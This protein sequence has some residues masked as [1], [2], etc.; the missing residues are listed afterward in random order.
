[1]TATEVPLA[2]AAAARAVLPLCAPLSRHRQPIAVSDVGA[3][4]LAV[5][6][7]VPTALLNGL[8]NLASIDD[9]TLRRAGNA[10][11]AAMVMA[12][13]R[14]WPRCWRS[15]RRA[16][17]GWRDQARAAASQAWPAREKSSPPQAW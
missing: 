16:H 2:M 4:A 14:R 12:S 3:A 1:M 7:A 17:R 5:R 10:Q 6:A 11:A 8:I 9:P 15:R 13:T